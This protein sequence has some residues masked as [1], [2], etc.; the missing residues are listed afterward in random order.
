MS[1]KKLIAVLAFSLPFAATAQAPAIKLKLSGDLNHR[2]AY[3]NQA[4]FFSAAETIRSATP[5]IN[6]D[7]VEEF[8]GEFKYRLT[9]EA[10]TEDNAVKGVYGL[11]IGAIRFGNGGTKLSG[12]DAIGTQGGGYS[13]DGDNYETRWAY[14]DFGLPGS[15]KNRVQVGL[16]PF[17]ANKFLWA[18]N[19]TGIQLKGEFAPVAYTLAWMR[20]NEIFNTTR[21]DQEFYADG[22]AY[23]LRGDFAPMKDVKAGLFGLYQHRNSETPGAAAVLGDLTYRLR[24][25]PAGVDYDHFTVGLDGALT[26]GNIFVNADFMYQFGKILQG[27]AAT[28]RSMDVSAF[29]AHAD[30]GVNLGAA[31]VTYTG[32]Y[33]SGDDDLTDNDVKN[34]IP[35]DVNLFDSVIFYLGGYTDDTFFVNSP[36]FGNF[37]A[38]FNKLALDYKMSPKTTVGVA[39]IYAMTAEDV[40]LDNGAKENVLGTEFDAYISHKVTPNVEVALNAGYL[41]SGDVM[42]AFEG[43]TIGGNGK[44]DE[45][46]FRT[47]ARIRYTF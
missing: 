40:T 3:T 21:T 46:I 9:F 38:I 16:L 7:T 25:F 45:D 31:K 11:E 24:D 10:A 32:W 18:E 15:M 34:F 13:G 28:R 12:T 44:A 29:F 36:G 8:W 4:A 26:F 37:G 1:L 35:T 33:S 27:A 20:G 47:T 43:G 39:A 30:V 2:F 17:V 23:F 22:D 41:V 6:K 19:A 14:I 42:D 5:I